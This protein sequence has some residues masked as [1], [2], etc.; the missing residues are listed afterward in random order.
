M[1]STEQVVADKWM[2]RAWC[3]QRFTRVRYWKDL[4]TGG[5]FLALEQPDVLVE[6]LRTFFWLV[7]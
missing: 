2:P 4:D 3:E 6:E 7:R 5:H 1:P